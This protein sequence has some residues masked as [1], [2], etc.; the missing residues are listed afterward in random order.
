M[1]GEETHIDFNHLV[2]RYLSG[3][4]SPEELSGFQEVLRKDPGKQE[5]LDEFRKIWDSTGAVSTEERYDLEREWALMQEKL[6]GFK[7][8]SGFGK[9]S[10]GGGRSLLYYSYRIAA[11][12]VV[13][14]M[15]TLSWFYVTRMAGMERVVAENEPVEVILDDGT[16]VIV[17]RHS[18][19]RYSRKFDQQERKVYL[20]GEAWFD[21]TRDASKPFVIDAGAALVEVLG[22]SFNVNAYKEN[23]TVEI[24]VESG[25]VAL[26]AKQ[27]TK[28]LIVMK[29]GSGGTYHKSQREL[30][31][32]PSSDPNS[33]SW[34]TREL[35]FEGSTL[36]EVADLVNRVYGV[37]IV[38]MNRELA[39]CPITVTFRDQTLE[40][41]LNV[42][43][44]TLDLQAT[45]VG[46]EIRLDGEGCVE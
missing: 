35:F 19:L 23:P 1:S 3:E 46:D 28:D 33:I 18:R 22:T 29:A 44:I 42:L 21:V 13:G 34:K 15:L 14:L 27:D 7:N 30:K 5:L 10:G 31:L 45:Q 8:E 20:T 4:L 12:F 37:N 39:S 6:P 9:T 25:M 2:T 41:I 16:E 24:T 17:N 32:I 26:S 43:E 11:V 36:R 38:I 40:A